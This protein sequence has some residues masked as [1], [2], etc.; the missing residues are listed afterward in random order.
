MG[1]PER[2]SD[3]RLDSWKA[4][5]AFLGRDER[6][7]RRW[8]KEN[9]LPVHRVPGS[10]KGRVFAYEN[11]LS[12]WLAAP[13]VGA[14]VVPPAP[15]LQA[16]APPASRTQSSSSLSSLAKWLVPFA[17]L[18][19][20]VF[21]LFRYRRAHSS[22]VEPHIP[23]AAAQDFYLKGRYYWNKR[24]PGDLDRAVDLF[25]QAIVQDPNYASAYVGLADSYNLLREYS[26]MP[27]S[28]AFPRAR[29]AAQKAVDLDPQ[30]ADA[31]TSLAFALFWG[32]LDVPGAETHFKRALELDPNNTRSHHWYATF[33][34][35]LGRWP[36]ALDQI[37][38]AR[39]LD[40][41]SSAILADKGFILDH[42][43][44][45]Q[46]ALQ[47]LRQLETAEP[48]FISPHRYLAELYFFADENTLYLTETETVARLQ[49]DANTDLVLA[50]MKKGF[51]MHGRPG[52]LQGKMQ[53]DQ[54][55]YDQGLASDLTL[56][57]DYSLLNDR[58]DSLRH[59]NLACDKHDLALSTLLIARAFDNVRHDPAFQGVLHRAGLVGATPR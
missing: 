9:A 5:A 42:S 55:L 11:E 13:R 58:N 15:R 16:V 32:S 22:L 44:D 30:S 17:L 38:R 3:R 46:Q 28:E 43:G 1:A 31:H 35:E 20:C 7:V 10:S 18:S 47:L 27:A 29:S 8:E 50:A 36:E 37:E 53:A 39:Q 52:L 2:I 34:A 26:V 57:A 14:Q 40:P 49:H 6:T 25:T 12:E 33:L 23:T 51:S 24:T 4:I 19:G 59:L 56:A 45:H 21:G 54:Q 41:S 48:D